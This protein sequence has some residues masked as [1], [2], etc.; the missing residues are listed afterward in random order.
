MTDCARRSGS[1][2]RRRRRLRA[3]IVAP[4]AAMLAL[5]LPTAGQA[6]LTTVGSPLSVPAT[7]NTAENL[8]YTGTNTNVLPNAE[9]PTGVAH[10]SHY[11]ADTALWNAGLASGQ[12][13]I[14][15]PGQAVK[16]SLEGCAEQAPGGPPPLTQIH[17][18]TFHPLGSSGKYRVELSSQPFELPVCGLGGAN[19]STV[20]TYEPINLCV[21]R[22]DVVSLNDEGGFVEKYYRSG[23][24][25]E[26]IGS[27]P[28]SSLDA[29]IKNEGT[30]NGS[31]I[32]PLVTGAMEGFS[33]ASNEE[34]MLQVTL[35]TGPD[36]RYVC[37]GGTKDAPPVLSTVDVHPQ[38][39]GINNSRI[40]LVAVYCRPA[41][42]CRGNATLSFNGQR[43]GHTSFDLNGNSTNHVPIRLAP[44]VMGA[45]R[46]GHGI[47][48]TVLVSSG[49]TTMTQTVNVKIF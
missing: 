3:V 45:I 6:A 27:V 38:T 21:N 49:H 4:G 28:G 24:P 32:S 41:G 42:G 5:A 13:T 20:S 19:G 7:L 16:V 8:G 43:V 39:D 12:A 37:A 2:A 30:G 46:R 48:T 17:F 40:V 33:S 34:L 36:A 23:V 29:F 35:G 25:Y 26:V 18:Q 47:A 11:G 22:G 44:S 9:F 31:L 10:T 1:A 15:A 14:P